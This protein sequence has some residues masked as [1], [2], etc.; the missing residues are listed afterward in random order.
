MSAPEAAVAKPRGLSIL[1]KAA[2]F[3]AGDGMVCTIAKG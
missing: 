1:R 3:S 2:T